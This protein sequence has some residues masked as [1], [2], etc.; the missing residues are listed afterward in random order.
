MHAAAGAYRVPRIAVTGMGLV[1][2]LGAGTYARRYCRR[3]TL[4]VVLQE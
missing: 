3:M 2:P 1:S 4:A